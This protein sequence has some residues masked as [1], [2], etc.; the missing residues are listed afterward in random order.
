[1]ATKKAKKSR[2][3]KKDKILL[4]L[5]PFFALAWVYPALSDGGVVQM[6]RSSGRY[7]ITVFTAPVPLRA[8]PADIS[9]LIQDRNSH[10]PVLDAEV[11]MSLYKEGRE[12]IRAEARREQAT[13][14]LLYAA[15][16][17]LPEAGRWKIEVTVVRNSEETR[18]SGPMM[19]A[20]PLPFL[21]AYWWMLALPPVAI[22]L[23]VI[24][25]WLK[26][27]LHHKNH[28]KRTQKTQILPFV[29]FVSPYVLFVVNLRF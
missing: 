23:F 16:V 13:N 7:V 14:K 24:N 12:A 1:M 29:L 4:P 21:L 22:G 25:Q 10:H 2:R 11:T 17:S 15:L 20:P 28:K 6:Q 18:L 8:G 27:K 19:V 5:L 9:I 26:R 3:G